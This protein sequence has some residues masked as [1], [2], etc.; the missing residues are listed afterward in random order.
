VGVVWCTRFERQCVVLLC[1]SCSGLSGY[2]RACHFYFIPSIGGITD[3]NSVSQP[4]PK[5]HTF[6]INVDHLFPTHHLLIAA[7]PQSPNPQ[8]PSGISPQASHLPSLISNPFFKIAL[9]R[10]MPVMYELHSRANREAKD[11]A[12]SRE[13][14]PA[15]CGTLT[16][17][18]KG[19]GGHWG[20]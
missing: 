14:R 13:L 4:T 1:V 9:T 16:L 20:M 19:D 7:N 3:L 15:S 11:E 2:T 17:G 8:N 10:A 6:F 12:D 18:G 5:Y